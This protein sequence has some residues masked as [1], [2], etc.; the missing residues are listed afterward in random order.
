ML[1]SFAIIEACNITSGLA[2]EPTRTL[3]D[4][5]S[6]A[7]VTLSTDREQD[8]RVL[9][10]NFSSRGVLFSVST[11]TSNPK[12]KN[13]E[14]SPSYATPVM[15]KTTHSRDANPFS[16]YYSVLVNN[17][18]FETG[19]TLT[20]WT[21]AGAC[22]DF[23]NVPVSEAFDSKPDRAGRSTD[24]LRE[25][26]IAYAADWQESLQEG[27]VYLRSIFYSPR[28]ESV[29]LQLLNPQGKVTLFTP[30]NSGQAVALQ[31]V[32]T[33]TSNNNS[34]TGAIQSIQQVMDLV[35]EKKVCVTNTGITTKYWWNP[36][37]VYSQIGS[38]RSIQAESNALTAGQS[39]LGFK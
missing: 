22:V 38:Q 39:C 16:S 25:W 37:E 17:T 36:R 5:G 15:M 33:M 31:G 12:E 26:E 34:Q 4:S 2:A 14:F 18:P 23:S 6:N 21:G 11:N 7:A 1:T 8:F 13:L 35:K 24:S 3:R 29:A 9:N 19:D 20:Y 27:D 10:S 30:D 28:S 32:S